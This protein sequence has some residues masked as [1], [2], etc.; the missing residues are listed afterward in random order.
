MLLSETQVKVNGR[1]YFCFCPLDLYVFCLPSDLLRRSSAV[2]IEQAHCIVRPPLVHQPTTSTNDV[3]VP[4]K[5]AC[6]D[7]GPDKTLATMTILRSSRWLHQYKAL[8]ALKICSWSTRCWRGHGTHFNY[9]KMHSS[10]S[11]VI[12][13]SGVHFCGVH[14]NT[15]SS[16]AE[17]YFAEST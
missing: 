10:G 13:V 17:C 8:P 14:S 6:C 5:D 12:P 9:S 7:S 11:P 15:I 1:I 3:T 2:V 4:I 16:F